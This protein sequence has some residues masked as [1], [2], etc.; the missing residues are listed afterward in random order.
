MLP[1][2]DTRNTWVNRRNAKTADHTYAQM[3]NALL[4]ARGIENLENNQQVEL[5]IVRKKQ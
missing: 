4:G 5:I 2:T 3:V 1:I